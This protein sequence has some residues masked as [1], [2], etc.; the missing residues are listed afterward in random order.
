MLDNIKSYS[1]RFFFFFGHQAQIVLSVSELYSEDSLGNCLAWQ[2]LQLMP[3][4]CA[5]LLCNIL[6]ESLFR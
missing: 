5:C 2:L 6:S 1:G 4:G 3:V